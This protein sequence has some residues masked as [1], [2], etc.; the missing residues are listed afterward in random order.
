LRAQRNAIPA[1]KYE[2]HVLGE[3]AREVATAK[4]FVQEKL[5][6]CLIAFLIGSDSILGST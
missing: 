4:A 3:F 6:S 1:N 5:T 2:K